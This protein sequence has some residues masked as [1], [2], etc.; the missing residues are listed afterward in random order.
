VLVEQNL[1]AALPLAERVYIINTGH[2]AHQ[3]PAAEIKA[4]PELLRYR[5]A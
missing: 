2:I 1:A 4:Q 5:G 3:G